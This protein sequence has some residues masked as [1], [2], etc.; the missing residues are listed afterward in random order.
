VEGPSRST[1]RRPFFC[2]GGLPF[3][4]GDGV[5]SGR[6]VLPSTQHVDRATVLPVFAR[7]RIDLFSRRTGSTMVGSSRSTGRSHPLLEAERRGS[8]HAQEWFYAFSMPWDEIPFKLESESILYDTL[9]GS[10]SASDRA[11]TLSVIPSSEAE[12]FTKG[13]G[14]AVPSLPQRGWEVEGRRRKEWGRR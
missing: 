2:K 8:Y 14:E 11:P 4:K 9:F 1:V 7:R 6:K 13:E 3:P 5:A 10:E 12:T